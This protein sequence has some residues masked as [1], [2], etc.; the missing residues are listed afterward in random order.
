MTLWLLLRGG[1]P[2]TANRQLATLAL[3]Y[4]DMTLGGVE[5]R[6]PLI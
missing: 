4:I 1:S 3:Y 2:P 5:N 6:R